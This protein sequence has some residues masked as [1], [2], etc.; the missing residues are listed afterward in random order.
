MENIETLFN[1]SADIH[2]FSKGYFRYLCGLMDRLDMGVIEGIVREFDKAH[3]N[4]NTVFFIGNG[5]SASTASHM[6]ND[7][8]LGT[9]KDEKLPFRAISLTDNVSSITAIAND[10]GYDNIFIRQLNLYYKRGDKLV[11]ISASGNSPNVVNAARW[12][13]KRGGRVIGLVGFD[14]GKLKEISDICVH[15]NTPKGEYGPVE[16]IHMIMD[17]L[18]YTWMWF[19]KRKG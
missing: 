2:Q 3:K 18:I 17:H 8:G 7:F 6:A 13:K 19:K 11:A 12:V 1:N 5:G 4:R 14:G 16:D 9:R 15:V 10:S